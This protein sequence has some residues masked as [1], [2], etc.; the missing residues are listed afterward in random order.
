[1]P[2]LV[3]QLK[4]AV[5]GVEKYKV[6]LGLPVDLPT[7]MNQEMADLTLSDNSHKQGIAVLKTRRASL[8][9]MM[10]ASRAFASLL[11]ELLKPSLGKKY[12]L[13]WQAIGFGSRL[14]IPGSVGPMLTL[15]AGM[16][17]YL[18]AN[19]GAENAALN[20]TAARAEALHDDLLGF[21]VAVAEGQSSRT[22]LSTARAGKAKLVQRRLR[23]LLDDLKVA[24]PSTDP[25]W[26]E[27]GFNIPGLLA[28]PAIP[29]NVIALLVGP[30]AA[31]VKWDHA[32]RAE[33]YHLW[34]RVMG[35]DDAMV[36]VETREDLDF[37]FENLP[38]GK[39]IRLAVSA[40]NNGGESALSEAV[41][42]VTP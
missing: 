4:L 2:T 12:S 29:A 26:L 30:T 15:L 17:T 22:S 5:A 9:S 25:R 8:R 21:R 6:T 10:A 23:S 20:I 40:V 37:V 1:M 42:V 28:V 18:S 31:A 36:L 3:N 14:Q 19:P 13:E 38:A 33:R 39:T 11:K 16:K 41:T 24:M 27:F 34:K 35:V 7:T 32:A